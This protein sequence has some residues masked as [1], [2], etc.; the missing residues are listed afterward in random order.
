MQSRSHRREPLKTQHSVQRQGILAVGP[1]PNKR[2]SYQDWGTKRIHSFPQSPV[3]PSR[4]EIN[5][6]NA[7]GALIF[8]TL[9]LLL[10]PA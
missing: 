6:I 2:V 4:A 1:G 7:D 9:G 3:S 5:A 8:A 10:L